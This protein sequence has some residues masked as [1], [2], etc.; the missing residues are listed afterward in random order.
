MC[1]IRVSSKIELSSAPTPM[2]YNYPHL[3]FNAGTVSTL[4][5]VSDQTIIM[6]R[7]KTERMTVLDAKN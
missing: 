4:R 6:D 1:V 3:D 2:E 5:S 7:S